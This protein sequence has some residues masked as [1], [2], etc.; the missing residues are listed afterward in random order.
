MRVSESERERE[1]DCCLFRWSKHWAIINE[2]SSGDWDR[3]LNWT[4]DIENK[5]YKFCICVY[6]RVSESERESEREREKDLN[7]TKDIVND[8]NKI[9]T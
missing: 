9:N 4:K 8:D 5:H 3:H 2:D 6:M 1:Q 7:W